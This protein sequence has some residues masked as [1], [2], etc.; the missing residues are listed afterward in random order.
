MR[1]LLLILLFFTF[2]SAFSQFTEE[3][4]QA[5]IKRGNTEEMIYEWN[6]SFAFGEY[7]L[8]DMISNALIKRASTNKNYMF[9]KAVTTFHYEKNYFKAEKLL[10]KAIT[11]VSTDFDWESGRE[12]RAPSEALY[13]YAYCLENQGK[14]E[15][16]VKYYKEFLDK[17]IGVTNIYTKTASLKIVNKEVAA[18][19]KEK[20]KKVE[21]R[22]LGDSVNS[23][24]PEYAPI[25]S[26]DGSTIYFT[27]RIPWKEDTLKEYLEDFTNFSTEDIYVSYKKTDTTW[28]SPERLAF[29]KLQNNE[30]TVSIS[31]DERTLYLYRDSE[32]GGDIFYIDLSNEKIDTVLHVDI[33]EVNSD[34]WDSHMFIS[35][36][37]KTIFF[38][39]DRPG[40]FGGR[41]IYRII[42]LPDGSWSKPFNLGDQINTPFD[43]DSPFLSIDN[44][45]LYFSSNSEKSMGGFDIFVSL[46]MDNNS[47]SSPIN[48]GYP[49]N[50]EKDDIYY[51][52]TADGLKAYF[53][54]NRL[55]GK[56][57][58]DI[59]EV[60][61]IDKA[62]KSSFIISGHLLYE[63]LSKIDP[64]I[65]LALTCQ[66]CDSNEKK[67]IK[68]R[69]RDGFFISALFP[70]REYI[71]EVLSKENTILYTESFETSCKENIE[72]IEKEIK[73]KR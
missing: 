47:W 56:G 7:K 36:D 10:K 29:C 54:S 26:P 67:I 2:S 35:N 19:Y 63:D 21:V 51:T 3:E 42:K 69:M 62:D 33:P 45:T 34:S 30:A 43:E 6:E 73:V 32:R 53:S 61:Y 68:T 5:V 18:K 72:K 59:Y 8:T 70:C 4:T 65:S 44:K 31:A 20:A 11:N 16:S 15:E 37:N 22:L 1:Y 64:S 17:N 25:I 40:G 27:S 12:A 57:S 28:T 60:N 46:L 24:Y 41:D 39:S 66:N 9:R 38:S 48:M 71:L 55:D 58:V 23:T 50:S 14:Y 13:Y 49:I 52:S